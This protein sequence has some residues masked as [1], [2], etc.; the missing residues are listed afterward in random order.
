MDVSRG[1]VGGGRPRGS[2]RRDA[3]ERGRGGLR[4]SGGKST[5]NQRREAEGKWEEG[6]RSGRQ[7]CRREDSTCENTSESRSHQVCHRLVAFRFRLI[8]WFYFGSG[9]SINMKRGA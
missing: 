6:R 1:E 8:T 9:F 7:G 2:G 3:E 5:G 4:R